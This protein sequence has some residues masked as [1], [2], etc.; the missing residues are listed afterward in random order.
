MSY[1]EPSSN[2]RSQAAAL[3]A[4]GLRAIN[5]LLALAGLACLLAAVAG[6]LAR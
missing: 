1:H 4:H 3:E 5:A 2:S 6:S